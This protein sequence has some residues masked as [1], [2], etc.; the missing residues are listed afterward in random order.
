MSLKWV[1]NDNAVL[2]GLRQMEE[3]RK[4][5]RKLLYSNTE[6]LE[7]EKQGESGRQENRNRRRIFSLLESSSTAAVPDHSFF[8]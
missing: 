4:K 6:Q 3:G 7:I 1:M 2:R 8:T 5:E